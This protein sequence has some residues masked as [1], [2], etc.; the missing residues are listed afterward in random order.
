[1][2][3]LTLEE[4]IRDLYDQLKNAGSAIPSLSEIHYLMNHDGDG[5][6]RRDCE[7]NLAIVTD[8]EIYDALGKRELIID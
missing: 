7:G 3:R 4:A 8:Q 2:R 6:P 5:N 1:M